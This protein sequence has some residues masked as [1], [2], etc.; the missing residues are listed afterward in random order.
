MTETVIDLFKVT[1][2]ELIY[3]NKVRPSD[4]PKVYTAA[5]AYEILMASWDM[6]KIELVEQCY[7]MLLDRAKNCLGL[8]LAS[9][10]GVSG[11]VVDP[12]I[13]FAKALKARASSII[14]SHNHPSGNLTPSRPD[15]ALTR[16]L[17]DGARLLDLDLDDHLIVTRHGYYSFNDDG[18][19]P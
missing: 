13:V 15:I 18:L 11:C 12:K 2:V 3:R 19:I 10:G 9:T 17:R 8:S 14:V 6:N 7:I 1:E 5:T 16:K 4:R